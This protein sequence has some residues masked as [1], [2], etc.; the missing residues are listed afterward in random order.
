M[1]GLLWIDPTLVEQ[2][3]ARSDDDGRCR[4]NRCRVRSLDVLVQLAVV[5]LPGVF[6]LH[7]FPRDLERACA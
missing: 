3:K 2:L 6:L 5:T 7:E 4:A 1:A